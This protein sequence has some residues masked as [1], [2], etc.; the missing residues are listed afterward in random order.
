MLRKGEARSARQTLSSGVLFIIV[1][2][3]ASS[4]SADAAAGMADTPTDRHDLRVGDTSKEYPED[5]SA[6]KG[7][8][9]KILDKPILNDSFRWD[10][11]LAYIRQHY[12]LDI[13]EPKIHPRMIVIH[14]TEIDSLDAS[15]KVLRPAVLPEQ[16]SDIR[17]EGMLN[18]AAHYLVDR[19]GAIYRLLPDTLFARHTIGLN[20]DAI[21]VENVGGTTRTPLTRAQLL[22]N[23]KLVRYLVQRHDIE[24]LIGHFEYG[25]FRGT[26]MWREKD[27]RYFTN[28]SDPGPKYMGDLRELIA[29]LRLKGA[30]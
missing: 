26:S 30:P 9:L 24:F 29:D 28:K 15:Y 2:L 27:P 3:A 8:A 10:L 7:S 13:R 18:V 14:C 22:A 20:M 19:D 11:S 5:F 25:A 17:N 6:R 23:A 12:G 4:A 1:A 21:G 16:R